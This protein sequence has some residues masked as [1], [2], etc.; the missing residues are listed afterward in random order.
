MGRAGVTCCV[1]YSN[2]S[3]S[4][5]P[6]FMQD[7]KQKWK[8]K[9]TKTNKKYIWIGMFMLKQQKR[10]KLLVLYLKGTVEYFGKY[11]YSLPDPEFDD[12]IDKYLISVW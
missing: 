8:N 1:L 9:L 10:T 3:L 7:N 4:P 11:A 5:I 6:Q 2:T 12:K